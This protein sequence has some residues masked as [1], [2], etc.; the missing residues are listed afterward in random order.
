MTKD[1]T[2]HDS[3]LSAMSRLQ[4]QLDAIM[5]A[6]KE[7]ILRHYGEYDPTKSSL[8]SWDALRA[9]IGNI[10]PDWR[11]QNEPRRLPYAPLPSIKLPFDKLAA[12]RDRLLKACKAGQNAL[13]DFLIPGES[14]G[15]ATASREICAAIEDAEKHDWQK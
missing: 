6:G 9:A 8:P 11:W 12:Q 13:A 14:P 15:A 1:E 3:R 5:V 2:M 4:A 10:E 7:L